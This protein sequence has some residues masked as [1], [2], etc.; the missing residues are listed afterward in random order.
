[1]KK[2]FSRGETTNNTK[3]KNAGITYTPIVIFRALVRGGRFFAEKEKRKK[4]NRRGD[5][6]LQKSMHENA[7][8]YIVTA[9]V[10][11]RAFIAPPHPTNMLDN[12]HKKKI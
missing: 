6:S 7:V 11:V 5:Y 10:S 8:L 3:K 9:A 2:I 1:M 12:S 4:W